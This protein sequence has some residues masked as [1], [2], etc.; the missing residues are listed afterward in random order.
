MTNFIPIFP[1]E[2]VIYPGE[3]VNLHIFEDRYK[4][5]INECFEAKK[6]FGIPAVINTRMEDLGS[7]V[8][9]LEI[10]E[11]FEDGRMNVK[12]KAIKVFRILEIIK[13]IP[14]KLY[15]GAIVNYPENALAQNRQLLK[16]VLAAIRKLH[17]LL[18][19][20]KDFKKPDDEL[21]SYDMAHHAG[22]SMEEEYEMLGL[23][24]EDYR[25]EYLKRH[26]TKVIPSAAAVEIMKNKIKLNGHFKELKGFDLDL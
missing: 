5:L 1:L 4:Q 21:T 7:L 24:N 3:L 14:D 8:E 15:S 11:R 18:Q 13:E 20:V 12:T 25:M 2:L 19:V 10:S 16:P 6:P 17:S 26:I 22:L 23:F 9:I